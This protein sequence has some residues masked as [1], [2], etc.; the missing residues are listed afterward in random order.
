M[1][2]L[3]LLQKAGSR[4]SISQASL[5]LNLRKLLQLCLFISRQRSFTHQTYSHYN[6]FK[7]IV[8]CDEISQKMKLSS[9]LTYCC[10]ISVCAVP[11][12]LQEVISGALS[13]L[14]K[15]QMRVLRSFSHSLEDLGLFLN[16]VILQQNVFNSLHVAD[17][18]D[19]TV[20]SV[21]FLGRAGGG[22]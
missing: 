22:H 9:T 15:I 3:P 18:L 1:L 21:S 4:T 13:L 20:N 8:H 5:V 16:P 19:K 12:I 14:Q 17:Y 2:V 11:F 7:A 10:L 6:L